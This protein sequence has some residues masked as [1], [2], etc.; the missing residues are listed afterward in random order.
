M[1]PIEVSGCRYQ[2]NDAG[3]RREEW[4]VTQTTKLSSNVIY[5]KEKGKENIK[6]NLEREKIKVS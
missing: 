4:V 2:N 3:A 5:P 1:V 6:E